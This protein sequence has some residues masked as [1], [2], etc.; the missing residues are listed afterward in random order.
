MKMPNLK[1]DNSISET[2]YQVIYKQILSGKLKPSD[3]IT[4]QGLSESMGISRAP[5]MEAFK[6]LAEDKLVILKPRS[7]C[8]IANLSSTEVEEIYEIRK[9]LESMA[10]EYAFNKIDR[11]ELKKIKQG[12]KDC[13]KLET[14]N[15]ITKEV[16]LDTKFHKMILALT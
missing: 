2:V 14:L 16:R 15:L 7:G 13:K 10:L 11:D 8:H 5:I 6:K 4:E 12:F 9:R 3:R 1:K